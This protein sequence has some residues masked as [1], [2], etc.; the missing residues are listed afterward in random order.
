M[1]KQLYGVTEPSDEWKTQTDI[2]NHA[3]DYQG[4]DPETLKPINLGVIQAK[5]FEGEDL[6]RLLF[7]SASEIETI[8]GE[9]A[10][11]EYVL[12]ATKKVAP[13]FLDPLNVMGPILTA[14]FEPDF[15]NYKKGGYQVQAVFQDPTI[16]FE[17]V[18]KWD[19]EM[20]RT[21][22]GFD[23]GKNYDPAMTLGLYLDGPN[24]AG[25]Y[26]L[27]VGFFR[28]ICTNGMFDEQWDMGSIRLKPQ[29]Y[30]P[31]AFGSWL[32]N[33]RKV[34]TSGDFS[35]PITQIPTKALSFVLDLWSRYSMN[36][37]EMT[38][39][40]AIEAM[41]VPDL[42]TR[43][44][45]Q[46]FVRPPMQ[47]TQEVMTQLETI[48]ESDAKTLDNL[49]VL[50]ALTNAA[51]FTGIADGRVQYLTDRVYSHLMDFLILGALMAGVTPVSEDRK[52]KVIEGVTV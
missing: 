27:R 23:A 2:L 44:F 22:E 10:Q 17:D 5:E 6:A 11:K 33:R 16:R 43:Q 14:G 25:S 19:L 3:A 7:R 28:L 32:D 12:G 26:R 42:I 9:T 30:L 18:I 4:L 46:V 41:A 51:N 20:L 8:D 35:I 36:R 40:E 1:S 37:I 13:G 38:S 24:K 48:G 52:I 31:S 45:R 39:S 21:L 47:M 15:I 49:D 29:D 50:N 34:L